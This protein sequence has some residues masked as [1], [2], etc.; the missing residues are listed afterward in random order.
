MGRR[1]QLLGGLR[2][3]H[4]LSDLRAHELGRGGVGLW[5]HVD[6]V[7]GEQD[8]ADTALGPAALEDSLALGGCGVERRALRDR[9][10]V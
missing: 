9:I 2:V 8:A 4:D 7:E 10:G 6:V 5:V 3:A 1:T